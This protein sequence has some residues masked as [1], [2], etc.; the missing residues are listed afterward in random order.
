MSF[1]IAA[2][3]NRTFLCAAIIVSAVAVMVADWQRIKW[4]LWDICEVLLV[5]FVIAYLRFAEPDGEFGGLIR[6]MLFGLVG[7]TVVAHVFR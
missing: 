4:E 1:V 3:R 5:L 6:G 2:M 7:M